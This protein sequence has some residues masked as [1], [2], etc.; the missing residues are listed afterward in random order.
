M[1]S[2]VKQKFQLSK[3]EKNKESGKGKKLVT[4]FDFFFI[5][6]LHF[7]SRSCFRKEKKVSS[8]F[9]FQ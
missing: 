2:T 1:R 5:F 6:M 4:G 9:P 3:K 8:D 7:D